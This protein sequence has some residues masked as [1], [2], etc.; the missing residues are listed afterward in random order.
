[1]RFHLNI[2][3]DVDTKDLDGLELPD[4]AA[5]KDVAIDGARSM[6]AEHVR[7]GRP[8][9]LHHRIEITDQAG[10][11]LATLPFRELITINDAIPDP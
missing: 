4:L 3:N 7:R 6:M 2:Y 8:I 1:M 9:S 10:K 11:V 5:A